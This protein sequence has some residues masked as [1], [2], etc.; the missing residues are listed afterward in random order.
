MM[1]GIGE[2]QPVVCR[3]QATVKMPR[4]PQQCS[5]SLG[6]ELEHGGGLL[7]LLAYEEECMVRRYC[8]QMSW[9]GSRSSG[10]S[11]NY[12]LLGCCSVMRMY[13]PST[14]FPAA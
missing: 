8:M 14:P 10:V 7:G 12:T 13:I 2:L 1:S 6:I 9:A 5:E 11:V 4:G 3:V